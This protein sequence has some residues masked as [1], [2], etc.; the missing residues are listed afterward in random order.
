MNLCRFY[1]ENINEN[2]ATLNNIE[3]RHLKVMRLNSGDSVEMVD[4]KGGLAIGIIEKIGKKDTLVKIENFKTYPEVN[5][6]KLI[7]AVSPAKGDRFD[8]MI[9]KCTEL[10][11][12]II[13]PTIYHRTVKLA[14]GQ[15]QFDRWQ[16]IAISAIKQCGRLWLPQIYEPM[17]LENAFQILNNKFNNTTFFI[18]RPGKNQLCLDKMDL[19]GENICGFIGPEGGMTESEESYLINK[20]CADLSLNEN[21]LRV[22]TAGVCF[23]SIIGYT[24]VR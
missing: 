20:G 15:K 10:G 22:E 24:K 17:N 8:W 14:K 7:L 12:D 13:V 18:C 19:Q 23:C 21:I 2:N 3:T 11:A 1:C 6:G 16:N 5:S 4:G 9:S